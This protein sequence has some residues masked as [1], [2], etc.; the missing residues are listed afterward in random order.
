M[1]NTG[2]SSPIISMQTY[3][4]WP[5]HSQ[6]PSVANADRTVSLGPQLSLEELVRR[7]KPAV[8]FLKGLEVSG[9]GFF[10]TETGLIATNAHLV[11]EDSSLLARLPNGAQLQ[12]TVDFTDPNLDLALVK[13]IP[14]SPDSVFPTLSLADSTLVHQ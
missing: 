10:I 3:N 2:S 11:R 9:S 6:E 14:P 5:V 13:A 1:A 8:V 7:A 12:T 4:R